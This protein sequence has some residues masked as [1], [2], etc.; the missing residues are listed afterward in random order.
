VIICCYLGVW[1]N[2]ANDGGGEGKHTKC[3]GLTLHDEVCKVQIWSGGSE[4]EQD[5]EH[6]KIVSQFHYKILIMNSN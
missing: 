1:V 3:E 6:I 4:A 2:V 5:S